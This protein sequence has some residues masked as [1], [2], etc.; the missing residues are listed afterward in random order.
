MRA[1]AAPDD[2]IRAPGDVD[3]A[4]RADAD[5]VTGALPL[6][7]RAGAEV[8]ADEPA[9]PECDGAF[10]APPE[11]AFA[12]RADAGGTP[13][14]AV[15]SGRDGPDAVPAVLPGRGCIAIA[16]GGVPCRGCIAMA[17]D[18]PRSGGADGAPVCAPDVGVGSPAGAAAD[19]E[20][21]D[22]GASSPTTCVSDNCGSFFDRADTHQIAPATANTAITT[23]A[24]ATSLFESVP[25]GALTMRVRSGCATLLM[26]VYS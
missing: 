21:P 18:G 4:D 22:A 9:V 23:K 6:A 2:A 26:L 10:P 25:A 20:A 24:G 12:D 11:P 15:V 7:D 16:P 1:G 19:G 8:E 5:V 13:A 14:D 3:C 17:P